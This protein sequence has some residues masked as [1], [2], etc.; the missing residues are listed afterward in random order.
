MIYIKAWGHDIGQLVEYKGI[1]KF[2]YYKHLCLLMSNAVLYKNIPVINLDY[3][4]EFLLLHF[5]FNG[6]LNFQ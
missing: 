2:K 3:E 4:K 6:L 5:I 1:I